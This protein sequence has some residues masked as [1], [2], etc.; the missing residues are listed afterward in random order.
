MRGDI[1]R[2]THFPGDICVRMKAIV[3]AYT[4][5]SLSAG[6][7]AYSFD[8]RVSAAGKR[9]ALSVWAI[10]LRSNHVSILNLSRA[11]QSG[12]VQY[13]YYVHCHKLAASADVTRVFV[14]KLLT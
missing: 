10:M 14:T 13:I 7:N 11:T 4:P 12:N 5:K 8:S 1:T 3:I 6:K 2:G 9:V